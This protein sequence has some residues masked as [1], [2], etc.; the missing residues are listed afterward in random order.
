M[1]SPITQVQA[2]AWLKR[3]YRTLTS[4][5]VLLALLL[6]FLPFLPALTGVIARS[7]PSRGNQAGSATDREVRLSQSTS[8]HAAGRGNPTI[9]LADGHEVLT[10]IR[11]S[12]VLQ[13]ALVQNLAQPLSLASA[14]FDEDG[15]ADLVSGYGYQGQGIASLLPGNVDSIYPNAPEAKQHRAA[16]A[17]TDAPFLSPARVSSVPVAVDFV[18]AGDFDAD[19][20]WDLVVGSRTAKALYLL[21]GDGRGGFPSIREIALPGVVTALTTGEINRADGLTDVVIGVTGEHGSQVLVFEG[22]G[23][24]LRAEPE[25]FELR[26][27][28]SSLALGQLGRTWRKEQRT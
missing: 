25:V 12:E 13:Q 4:V 20:H 6:V 16:G 11:G 7:S 3:C 2:F 21:T 9:N 19:S 27:A 18:G 8:V 22:P 24:A 10:A 5:Q 17:F 28:A 14:D 26:M 15:V 1:S 23:G